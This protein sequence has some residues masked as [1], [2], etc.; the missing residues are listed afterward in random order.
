M[1]NHAILHHGDCLEVLKTLPDNSVDSVVTD[2]PYHL[3]C[4]YPTDIEREIINTKMEALLTAVFVKTVS[5][6]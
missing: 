6:E 4:P 2:P 1:L 3:A 5:T